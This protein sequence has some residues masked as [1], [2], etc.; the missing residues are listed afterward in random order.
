MDK[1]VNVSNPHPKV[2]VIEGAHGTGKAG[3]PGFCCAFYSCLG[4]K[5]VLRC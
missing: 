1:G 4:M 5:E 3:F 2:V